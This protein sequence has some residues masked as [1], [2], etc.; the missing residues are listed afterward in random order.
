M[1][2]NLRLTLVFIL[3][4]LALLA[5]VAWLA[6]NSGKESLRSA[7]VS[8]LQSTAIEKQ[9]ALNEWVEEKRTD[10]SSLAASPTLLESTVYFM[11]NCF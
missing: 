6:Y 9:A 11:G 8:E 7:T 3:Y 10:I 5:V 4:A 2:L 1:K